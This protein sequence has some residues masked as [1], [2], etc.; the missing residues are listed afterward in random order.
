MMQCGVFKSDNKRTEWG[1]G[2]GGV[3]V[4]DGQSP[5]RARAWLGGGSGRDGAGIKTIF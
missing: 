4:N 2:W 5:G 3:M 1:W